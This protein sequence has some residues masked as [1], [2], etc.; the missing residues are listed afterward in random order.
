MPLHV[1]RQIEF[2][3][4]AAG[5]VFAAVCNNPNSIGII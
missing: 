2:D 4:A 3:I 1:K 5:P